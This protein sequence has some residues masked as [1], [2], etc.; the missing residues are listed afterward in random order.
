MWESAPSCAL[1]GHALVLLLA[2]PIG[3]LIGFVGIG[4]VLLVPLLATLGGCSERD[5]IGVALASFITLGAVSV[6]VRIRGAGMPKRA[7]WFLFGAMIPGAV[8]GALAVQRLPDGLLALFVAAA[9][10]ATGIWALRTPAAGGPA[11]DVPSVPALTAIGGVTG[12]ASALSGTGGPLVLMPLL[13]VRGVA[14]AEAISLARIAQFPVALSATL[15]RSAGSSLDLPTAGALSAVLLAGMLG[16]T[17][18]AASVQPGS[19]TRAV[20]WALLVAG[21]ALGLSALRRAFG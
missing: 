16:G 8:A 5:A 11:R 14:V 3:V 7:E 19:L 13:L 12:A 6:L 10:T 9:I 2:L 15:A 18:L 4:G 20:G 17:R 21:A 1:S